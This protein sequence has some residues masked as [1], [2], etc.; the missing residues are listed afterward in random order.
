MIG[1]WQRAARSLRQRL[2][3][4]LRVYLY[5][6]VG[7]HAPAEDPLRLRIDPGLFENHLRWFKKNRRLH[8]ADDYAAD[9]GARTA[10]DIAIT[11]DD[12][13]GDNFEHA[14]P[15]LLKYEVPATIF[16]ATAFV[17][18]GEP[19]WW[20][21][22]LE[23][24]RR[25][26]WPADASFPEAARM[27]KALGT[28]EREL[29][30]EARFGRPREGLD[31]AFR[32]AHRPLSSAEMVKMRD[33]GLVRFEPHSHSHTNMAV[34][35]E[36]GAREEIKRSQDFLER[37][38]GRRGRVF[39]Y[40]YG[41]P[42]DKNERTPDLLREAGLVAAYLAWGR[43]NTRCTDRYHLDRIQLRERLPEV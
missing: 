38:L 14:F 8:F 20:D 32:A 37:Y 27:L 19:P 40:P 29:L 12:G 13:Y 15:L 9:L 35:T 34:L 22:L 28:R 17:E 10:L 7:P 39:A 42:T 41:A 30:L 16:I 2:S 3:P 23:L 33:S 31:A 1:L 18:S 21:Q 4:P 26:G 11:F 25:P 36:A 43:A 24:S 5:H 6:R